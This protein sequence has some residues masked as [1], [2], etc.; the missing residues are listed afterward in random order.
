MKMPCEEWL[1]S[2][3][4]MMSWI[5]FKCSAVDILSHKTLPT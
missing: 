1:R 4:E 2:T 5:V 3:E